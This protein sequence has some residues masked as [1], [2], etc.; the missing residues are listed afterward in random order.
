M[1]ERIR[2]LRRRMIE[3]PLNACDP[4]EISRFPLR[5]TLVHLSQR[6]IMG[7]SYSLDLR[8]PVVGGVA[9]GACAC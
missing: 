6:W 5:R 4:T 2:P 9:R 7:K 1:S 8:E 3:A